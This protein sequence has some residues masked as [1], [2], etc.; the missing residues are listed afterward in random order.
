MCARARTHACA[1]LVLMHPVHSNE[2]FGQGD[3]KAGAAAGTN[4]SLNGGFNGLEAD[5]PS[6]WKQPTLF[7]A[8]ST[9]GE[10]VLMRGADLQ[11]SS[12]SEPPIRHPPWRTFVTFQHTMVKF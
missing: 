6:V 5:S 2:E 3:D 10:R 11:V 9:S 1:P 4:G 8:D 12:T 7:R